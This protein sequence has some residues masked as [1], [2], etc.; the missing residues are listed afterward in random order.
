MTMTFPTG[1]NTEFKRVPSGSHVA[2]CNLIA[3]CGLQPG[4]AL[5]PAPKHKLYIRFETP[6]ERVEYERN[7][8]SVEG[9]LTIGSFY[10]ASM[11]EKA[12]LRQ[13]LEG[14]RGRAFTEQEAANFDVSAI[15][16]KACM[17][18]VVESEH[19]GK[20]YA[21]IKGIGALP[22]GIPVP[23]AENPLLLYG[24][25]SKP[26]ELAKLPQWLQDKIANQLRE[27]PKAPTREQV[28]AA[29]ADQFED[30]DIPF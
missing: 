24:P 6:G 4:S 8:E 11:N 26:D 15:L 30:D 10:T 27:E 9:P 28:D 7:G 13:H 3:D 25:E 2:V 1:G 22:K 21:H 19:N 18:F 29:Q 16:G 14:W 12:I 23:E 20:T 5:Y 17:L